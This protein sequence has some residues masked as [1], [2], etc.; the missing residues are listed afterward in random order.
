MAT[1]LAFGEAVM[2][3]K[4]SRGMKSSASS[5]TLP[6]ASPACE[7][8][9]AVGGAELNAAVAFACAEGNAAS[10]HTASWISVLPAGAM[11]DHVLAAAADAGVDTAQVIRDDTPHSMLG[12]LHVVVRSAR[13]AVASLNTRKLPCSHPAQ[14]LL[15]RRRARARA[16]RRAAGRRQRPAAALPAPPLGLLHDGGR[17]VL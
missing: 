10:A 4:P 16:A 7:V 15:T 9:Q 6:L 2:T 17:G 8:V 11:G 12:T 13:L 14:D 1:M 3:F 5:Q